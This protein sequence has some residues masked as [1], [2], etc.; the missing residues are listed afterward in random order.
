MAPTETPLTAADVTADDESGE[1]EGERAFL[2]IYPDPE[3]QERS[4]VVELP[5][6]V[7]V[8]FGRSRASTVFLDHEKVSRHHAQV[9][10]KGRSILVEDLGS[11]N[12]TRVNGE[13]IEGVAR[14]SVGDAIGVGVALAV[15]GLTQ[16]LSRRMLIGGASYLEERLGAETDRAQRYRRPLGLI[17]LRLDGA[18]AAC[19]AAVDRVAGVL[20]RMDTFAEYGPDE[21]ALLLPE[22]DR[23]ATEA[24][25][26]RVVREARVAGLAQGGVA[27]HVGLAVC[28]E[29]GAEPGELVARARAALRTARTGGGD[30]GVASAPTE[31]LV[32]AD[33]VVADPQMERLYDLVRRVATTPMTVLLL[34]ETGVGKEVV[35][36]E[37]HRQS[38]RAERPFVKLNCASL[39][40]TLLEAELFGYERGA[41]TGADKRKAGYFEAAGGGTLFLDEI[42]EI[43]LS[44]QPKLLRVLE[45]RQLTRLGG[46]SEVTV[47]VRLL[48]ATNRDLEREIGR[49]RFRE[50]LY[51]RVSA[52]TLMVPPLRERPTEIPILA[53]R[54]AQ[55]F[56]RELDQG[57]AS[58][59]AEAMSLLR[60]YAW[61]G[62]VRE[63]R[64]AIERAV[65]LAG[66][67]TIELEHLPPRVREQS[68]AAHPGTPVVLGEGIDVREQ[69]AEVERA[70]IV[71]AM[72]EC[73]G[74]QT[75]AAQ[76]LGLSRRALIYKLEK[77]G[78]KPPP[79]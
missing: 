6:G 78:L 50:D 46:T 72:S 17:M 76:K 4:R 53:Q 3:S 45:H 56:A 44:L 79:R 74:N 19:E 59:S 49:G 65:V 26:R 34:G 38:E 69:I 13:R 75:R 24:A 40:E 14:V 28:P 32:A 22:A 12:G 18:S 60:A 31:R 41:F 42:G 35:A 70:A 9:I 10:R 5:D 61:P 7:P 43:P 25:A 37:I 66:S 8:T 11:R 30:D 54:F 23:P 27:V 15:V 47:D 36:Q 73:G 58:L 2:V 51:F 21:F 64:N 29:D 77:H 48:C 63:L 68:P 1:A 62:N 57:R 39:P 16:R 52:F 71:A 55:R 33:V 20:R 67:S